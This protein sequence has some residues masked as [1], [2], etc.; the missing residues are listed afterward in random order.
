MQSNAGNVSSYRMI[1]IVPKRDDM[2][3]NTGSGSKGRLN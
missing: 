2:N 3:L 1:V